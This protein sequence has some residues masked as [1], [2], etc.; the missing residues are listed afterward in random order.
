MRHF[1][2]TLRRA[3]RVLLLAAAVLCVTLWQ[4]PC[5]F[6]APTGDISNEASNPGE[7]MI[8]VDMQATVP[9]NFNGTV[10]VLLYHEGVGDY[11][12]VRCDALSDYRGTAKVPV[13]RYSV[14]EAYTDQD[15]LA[16]EAFVDVY[17]FEVGDTGHRIDVTVKYS[18]AGDQYSQNQGSSVEL[19]P[20]DWTNE[21]PKDDEKE[22]TP[23]PDVKDEPSADDTP[24]ETPVEDVE[25]TPEGDPGLA[26]SFLKILKSFGIFLVGSAVFAGIVFVIVF[27]VR[28]RNE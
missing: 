7:N 1:L 25:K 8:Y 23:T 26:G 5:A 4:L 9:D 17:E 10:S 22:D 20:D 24:E 19:P 11:Y 15:Q 27:F 2:F 3:G 13:G 21:P 16:F 6:A 18:N 12:T 14:E 28:K